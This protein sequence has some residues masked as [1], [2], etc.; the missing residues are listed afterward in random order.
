MGTGRRAAIGDVTFKIL[1]NQ[2]P[3][4]LA[5]MV[6]AYLANSL[7][8]LYEKDFMF[9]RSSGLS[10]NNDAQVYTYMN[11]WESSG[12]AGGTWDTSPLSTLRKSDFQT[13]VHCLQRGPI[14]LPL[15]PSG[16]LG[17]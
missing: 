17:H 9:T 2:V 1:P 3:A 13:L 4:S 16:R 12:R 14:T 7:V 10:P 6:V 11:V 8:K 5:Q 15:L